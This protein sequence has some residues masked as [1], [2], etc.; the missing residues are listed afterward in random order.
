MVNT[1]TA[2]IIIGIIIALIIFF[3]FAVVFMA[4]KNQD[5]VT[6]KYDKIGNVLNNLSNPYKS[7]DKELEKL[8]KLVSHIKDNHKNDK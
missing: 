6:K 7:E 3:N 4:R 5:K 2:T 1:N 8:S